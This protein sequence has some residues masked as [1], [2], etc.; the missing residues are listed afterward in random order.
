[1]GEEFIPNWTDGEIDSC[2]MQVIISLKNQGCGLNIESIAS[3]SSR[4]LKLIRNEWKNY[5]SLIEHHCKI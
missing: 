1:M 2:K 4:V 3:D 5:K